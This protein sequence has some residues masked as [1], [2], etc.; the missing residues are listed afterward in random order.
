[1]RGCLRVFCEGTYRDPP[2]RWRGTPPRRF[3][4]YRSMIRVSRRSPLKEA[5]SDNDELPSG[6]LSATHISSLRQRSW[7]INNK[8]C[9]VKINCVRVVYEQLAK[10]S[11][12]NVRVTRWWRFRSISSM[13]NTDWLSGRVNLQIAGMRSNIRLV[14]SDSKYI[15]NGIDFP[16]AVP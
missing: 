4:R 13:R 2:Q 10:K 3:S 6:A 1:M 9:V 11:S 14:P 16:D 8:S 7:S 12:N 15:G 5:K